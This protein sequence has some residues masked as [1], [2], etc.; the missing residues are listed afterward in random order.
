MVLRT[1][2]GVSDTLNLM[3]LPAAPGVFRDGTAGPDSDIAT[4][5]RLKNNQLVTPSN[6]IHPDD[7][8]VIY[9]AGMG[10]TSPAVE[11]GTAA[12]WIL[13]HSP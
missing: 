9:L 11:A 7:E 8:I 4:V 10:K 6:P 2:G 12:P 3:I 1:P 13:L 5:V